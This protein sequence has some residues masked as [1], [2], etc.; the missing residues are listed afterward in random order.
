MSLQS[1]GAEGK[2][3]GL[4]LLFHT[5]I[6]RLLTLIAL[7]VLFLVGCIP[8]ITIPNAIT[9]LSR[10]VIS[11]LREED[12][13]VVKTFW[14]A[15]KSEFLKTMAT[16]WIALLLLCG[17]LYGAL[18][19]WAA[20]SAVSTAIAMLCVIS[21]LILYAAACN[22]FYMLA[23]I[24][25]PVGALLKNAALLVFVRPAKGLLWCFVSFLILAGSAWYFPASLPMIALIG[26]SVSAL[27]ACFGVRDNIEKSVVS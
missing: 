8:L 5:M 11:L 4:R 3:S 21:G 10:C 19:Y 7:N 13:P 15:Y 26:C 18:F 22:L 27:F 1:D 9:A 2:Y 20:G 17:V 23:R 16:G 6:S 14:N 24:R 25:L 12:F